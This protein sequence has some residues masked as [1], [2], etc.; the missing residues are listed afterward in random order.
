MGQYSKYPNAIDTT[1]ELPLATDNIT[2][3]KAETVNRLRDAIVCIESEAGVNPSGS[4]A[5]IADRLD[6]MEDSG[7]GGAISI[8]KDSTVIQPQATTIIFQ[9]SASIIAGAPHEVIIDIPTTQQKQEKIT[10]TNGQ[11]SFSLSE[12]PLQANATVMYINGLKQTYGVDYTISGSLVSYLGVALQ[13]SDSVEFWYLFQEVGAIGTEAISNIVAVSAVNTSSYN[14]LLTD[15]HLSVN[16]STTSVTVYLPISPSIGLSF[17]IKDVNGSASSHSIIVNG[18]GYNIDGS[19]TFTMSA[20]YQ[21]I[22]VRFTGSR[23]SIV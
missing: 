13:S 15:F 6:S 8:K 7:G 5:T 11:T 3:V 23:W 17:E 10:V 16:C 21:C 20:S 4:F 19:A 9:G 22:T 1:T 12:A 2:P 18:N 14:I